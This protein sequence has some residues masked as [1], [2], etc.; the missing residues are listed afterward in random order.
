MGQGLLFPLRLDCEAALLHTHAPARAGRHRRA[1]GFTVVPKRGDMVCVDGLVSR[2]DLNGRFALVL[3][4][5]TTNG[6]VPIGIAPL[7]SDEVLNVMAC[8]PENVKMTPHQP[9]RVGTAW[10]NLAYA[11]K[12]A[13]KCTEAGAAYEVALDFMPAEHAPSLIDNMMKLCMAQLRESTAD[14]DRVNARMGHLMKQLFEPI[15]SLPEMHGLAFNYGIDFVPGYSGRMV[16][17]GV[18]PPEQQQQY[19]RMF[20]LD[21]GA[22]K[23]VHPNTGEGL[24]MSPLAMAALRSK[25]EGVPMRESELAFGNDLK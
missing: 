22:I 6:R 16:M 5:T 20:V 14:P 13:G 11:Y 8:K 17:L 4:A 3:G 9:E 2:P 15:T 18:S 1:M 10:N 24:P 25:R 7:Q 21:D 23:E 19:S 12:R